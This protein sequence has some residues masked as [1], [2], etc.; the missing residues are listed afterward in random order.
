MNPD[1]AIILCTYNPNMDYFNQQLMSIREQSYKNFILYIFDD[2]STMENLKKIKQSLSEYKIPH[3]LEVNENNL[4][5]CMNFIYALH[6]IPQ[7]K[8]YSFADQDDVWYKDKLKTG[9]EYLNQYDLYCSATRLINSSNKVIGF[10]YLNATPSF[11]HSLVQSIAGGNTFI[12]TKRIRDIIIHKKLNLPYFAHDWFIYQLASGA[13]LQI[14]YDSNYS[15]DYRIHDSNLTGTSS[16][17]I[18][19]VK[20]LVMLL[21]GDF[22]RWTSDNIITLKGYESYLTKENLEI[23]NILSVKRDSRLSDRLKL[24]HCHNFRRS[25]FLQNIAFYLALIL[26]K[27]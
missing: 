20:R 22:Q 26:K 18:H 13:G 19:K 7:H 9:I 3:A 14:F 16:S 8:F 6:K 10:N 23:L 5:C 15:I 2:K 25:S 4:G 27:I 21:K 24:Y 1:L 11:K 17:F 12:F